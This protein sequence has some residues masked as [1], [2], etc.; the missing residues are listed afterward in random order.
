M[1]NGISKGY[2]LVYEDKIL[3]ALIDDPTKSV[4]EMS[5]E[6]DSYRQKVWRKKKKFEN[7]NV[8]WG[9]T[10]V[11][12]ESKLNHVMY[13][14]LMKLEPMSEKLVDILV[15]RLMKKIPQKQQ[16]NLLNVLYING[17]YDLMVMFTASDHA[18]ARK[19][20][21][22]LRIEYKE[23]LIEKPVIVD[24]NFSLLREGKINPEIEKL[25][26]FVPE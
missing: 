5:K 9:Y 14:I 19:Y 11:V 7:H 10:S 21:D 17:Q 13:L 3:R 22:S 8:I 2:K 1:D 4:R 12:D 16:V 26:E 24:V 23:H 20:F 6:L 18:I 15:K 25:Y